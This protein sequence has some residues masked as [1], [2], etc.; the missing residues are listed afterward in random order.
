[1]ALLGG[2][3]L[4]LAVYEALNAIWKEHTLL[5]KLDKSQALKFAILI[6]EVFQALDICSVRGHEEEVLK[7]AMDEGLTI[8]DAAYL[9]MALETRH[10]LVTD[11]K[12]LAKK[13][14]KYLKV[15]KS[16]DLT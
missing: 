11:D 2:A 13:A 16:T 5:R 12:K 9:Y 4:D 7:L 15:L 8:Y 10:I 6:R 1:M 14:E 3:T